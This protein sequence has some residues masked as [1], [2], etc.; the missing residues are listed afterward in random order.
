ML[1][2]RSVSASFVE[3]LLFRDPAVSRVAS[4]TWLA[5]QTVAER[6]R[7]SGGGFVIKYLWCVGHRLIRGGVLVLQT[8]L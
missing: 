3:L 6:A 4:M 2:A 8:D 5:D 7:K 1:A